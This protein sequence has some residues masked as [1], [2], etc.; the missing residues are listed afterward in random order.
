MAELHY[1]DRKIEE[2]HLTEADMMLGRTPKDVTAIFKKIKE[3]DSEKAAFLSETEKLLEAYCLIFHGNV[4]REHLRKIL[5][6]IAKNRNRFIE[7]KNDDEQ[8]AYYYNYCRNMLKIAGIYALEDKQVRGYCY[9]ALYFARKKG[10]K[11][12]G[13]SSNLP[14]WVSNLMFKYNGRLMK[15]QKTFLEKSADTSLTKEQK[16]VLS[17]FLKTTTA[18]SNREIAKLLSLSKDSVNSYVTLLKEM[19]D[20]ER[21]D[22]IKMHYVN[23]DDIV[24]MRSGHKNEDEDDVEDDDF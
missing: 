19:G 10:R 20:K 21:Q 4:N 22:F 3:G 11:K 12:K 7:A 13:E 9:E 15:V 5:K 16:M 8:I 18:Q 23:P 14:E 24:A 6:Y 17:Y 2:Y 1:L